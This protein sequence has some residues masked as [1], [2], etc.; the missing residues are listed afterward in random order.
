MVEMNVK[1]RT[2]K[3]DVVISGVGLHTGKTVSMTIKQAPENHW[4]KFKE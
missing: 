4:Y 1:Q 2:I 3:Q